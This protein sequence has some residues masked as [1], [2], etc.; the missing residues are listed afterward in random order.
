MNAR[1]AQWV[2]ALPVGY[3]RLCPFGDYVV[4]TKAEASKFDTR[5][6]AERAIARVRMPCLDARDLRATV[7]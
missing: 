1:R 5:E 3:V 6:D 7:A 4:G 2:L